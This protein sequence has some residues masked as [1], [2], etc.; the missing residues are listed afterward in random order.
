[1]AGNCFDMTLG[2]MGIANDLWGLP[3]QMV[4]GHYDGMSH[5]WAKIGNRNYDPTRRALEGTYNPPPQGPRPKGPESGD[6]IIVQ[7]LAKCMVL[8]I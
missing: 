7:F 8:K 2:I 1:M 3:A 5:V 6:T 4:W